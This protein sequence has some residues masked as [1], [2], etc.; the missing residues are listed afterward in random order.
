[1]MTGYLFHDT[2]VWPGAYD[3]A[4]C[5]KHHTLQQS[6]RHGESNA[7]RP[8]R[9]DWLRPGVNIDLTEGNINVRSGKQP[10]H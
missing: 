5:T 6:C 8:F 3:C 9:A 1:M 10:Q 2:P 7:S 4:D